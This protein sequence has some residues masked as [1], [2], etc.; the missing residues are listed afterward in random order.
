MSPPAAF[1][2]WIA[3]LPRW[4]GWLQLTAERAYAHAEEEYDNQYGVSAP[5][6]EEGEGLCALLKTHGVDTTGPALEIGCGTGRLTYGLAKHYPGPDF[7]ITDPSPAFLRITQKQFPGGAGGGP[8]RLHFAVLNADDPGKLPAD[9]FSLIAMRSTLHHILEPDA[10]I[11]ACARTLRPGGALVMG[12]EPVESGYLLM[13]MMAR[14]IE[15]VLHQAG[16]AMTPAWRKQ[17][18]D[19]TETVRFCCRRD[20][21]KRKAEDKHFFRVHE[22]SNLGHSLGL[23]LRFF[24]NAAFSDFAPPHQPA[25][26]GFT[27]F[28]LEYLQY[29]MLF[30]PEFLAHIRRHLEP[31]FK[32]I[33]DCYRSHVGPTINGVYLLHKTPARS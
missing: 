5:E 18:Q 32:Y 31:H 28:F 6:P 23:H 11:T 15:P 3:T 10:F 9:M 27:H 29:C 1:A 8:A 14:M 2:P 25:F 24:P 4:Q 33:D 22:L 17:V 7:L 12:A 13:G 30:D 26:E 19:L 21:D 20:L 16:V